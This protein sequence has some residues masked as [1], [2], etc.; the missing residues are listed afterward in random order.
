MTCLRSESIVLTINEEF[1]FSRREADNFKQLLQLPTHQYVIERFFTVSNDKRQ[2][3][4]QSCSDIAHEIRDIWTFCNV[5]CQEQYRVKRQL[6]TYISVI[7]KLTQQNIKRRNDKW[8]NSIKKH[9]ETLEDGFNIF[10]DTDK[11]VNGVEYGDEE[12]NL[13]RDNC[14]SMDEKGEVR[15]Y[16]LE[17]LL[18]IAQFQ[19]GHNN[20][21][22]IFA[23]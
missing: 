8:H 3:F 15:A 22:L 16:L 4:G 12:K 1:K 19:D 11:K 21:N 6:D 13:Y 10:C 20:Y 18:F 7:K 9:F 23:D 5:P 2:P 17:L 14:L